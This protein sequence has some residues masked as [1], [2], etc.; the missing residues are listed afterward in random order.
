M[1]TVN[2][3]F[4]RNSGKPRSREGVSNSKRT[5]RVLSGAL[6]AQSGVAAGAPATATSVEVQFLLYSEHLF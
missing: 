5:W 3:E 4:L 6:T 2:L 1:K